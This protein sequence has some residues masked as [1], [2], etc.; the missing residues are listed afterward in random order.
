MS[1]ETTNLTEATKAPE[2]KLTYIHKILGFFLL[3]ILLYIVNREV[4]VTKSESQTQYETW[5]QDT[6]SKTQTSLNNEAL[7]DITLTVI[8]EKST[9]PSSEQLL[10]AN[11]I[12]H[13]RDRIL[14]LLQLIKEAGLYDFQTD[15][16]T[17]KPGDIILKIQ[18]PEKTFTLKFRPR[19]VEANVKASLMLKLFD[20]YSKDKIPDNLAK[21]MNSEELSYIKENVANI[22]EGDELSKN[23]NP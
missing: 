19:D 23:A 3:A 18:S 7:P 10:T 5:L 11:N 21:L 12:A 22:F 13:G 9:L 6:E 4:P 2:Y 16:L 1:E 20:E 15:I 17:T 14:R 8:P